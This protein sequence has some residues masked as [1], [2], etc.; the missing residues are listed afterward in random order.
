MYTLY[1]KKIKYFHEPKEKELE[2]TEF[3]VYDNSTKT[4]ADFQP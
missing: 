3:G 4:Q 2:S 1:T